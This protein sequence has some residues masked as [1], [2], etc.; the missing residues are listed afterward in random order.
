VAPLRRNR[1]FVLLQAGQLLSATGSES[2][3]VVYPLLVLA[4]THSPAKAGVVTFARYLAMAL[5]ALP[6]GTMADRFDRRRLMIAADAVRA[7]AMAALVAAIVSD[8]LAFW[9]LVVVATIE[10]AG[11]AV[12][13]PAAAGALKSIVPPEQLADAAGIQQ[14][15]SAA[16]AIAGPPLGG[17]L[18]TA[19]R[20]V[21]FVVDAVSYVASTASLLAMRTR[22]QEDR[23]VDPKRLAKRL[24]EGARFLWSNAFLRTAAFLY[25]L[26]DVI[27][28]GLLLAVVVIGDR[29]GLSSAAIGLL[30][31]ILGAGILAGA[32]ISPLARRALSVRVILLLELWAWTGSAVFLIHPD[33]YVLVAAQIPCMLAIPITDSVVIAYRLAITPDRLVGRVES[34]RS[35]ISLLLAPLGPLLAGLLLGATSERATIAAF[36]ALGLVLAL[37]GTASRAIRDAPALR[38]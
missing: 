8:A 9:Q 29:Q 16:V 19:G 20:A 23:E 30:T 32:L 27:G 31:A 4:I 25:G 6:A 34:V 22:F 36:A 37:W 14:T 11:Y 7:L 17:A 21:P 38:R 1:D 24:A 35:T 5:T 2:T 28:L 12:F 3:T 26:T 13:S 33:V 15:R 18:L 10:G